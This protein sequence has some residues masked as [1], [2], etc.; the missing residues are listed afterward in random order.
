MLKIEK[1]MIQNGPH[2]K[3]GFKGVVSSGDTPKDKVRYHIDSEVGDIFDLVADMSKMIWILNRKIDGTVTEE[4]IIT[5]QK[6]KDRSDK[7]TEIIEQYY[8]K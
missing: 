5:E 2:I 3:Q 8:K 6:I 7:V 4:D 1:T